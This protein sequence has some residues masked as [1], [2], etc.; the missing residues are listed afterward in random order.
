MAVVQSPKAGG[1]FE[2]K[3]VARLPKEGLYGAFLSHYTMPKIYSTRFGEKEQMVFRFVVTH[4]QAYR[5]LAK[6]SSAFV[7]VTNV[8]SEKSNL[9]A[10]LYALFGGKRT[11]DEIANGEGIFDY[12]N[13]IARPVS[14]IL[15]PYDTP[16]KDGL[17]GNSVKSIMPAD[18]EMK[19]ALKGLYDTKVI[20]T[21]DKTGLHYL[22]SPCEEY[23]DEKPAQKMTAE[24]LGFTADD[25]AGLESPD[26]W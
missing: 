18:D 24:D 21:N 4:D 19:A 9:V 10:V 17:F 3:Q 14:L 23:E 6:N 7:K 8:I 1:E 26:N 20:K 25:F 15:K 11:K 13:F 5:K 16:D 2:R 12:D 22:A